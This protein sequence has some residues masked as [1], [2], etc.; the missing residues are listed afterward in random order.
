M[1]ELVKRYYPPKQE[2]QAVQLSGNEQV[3]QLELQGE[4]KRTVVFYVN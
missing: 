4:H 2:V 3:L 1:Q